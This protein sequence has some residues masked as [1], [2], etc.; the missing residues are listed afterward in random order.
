[1][2]LNDGLAATRSGK[3]LSTKNYAVNVHFG[4]KVRIT[5]KSTATKIQ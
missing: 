2:G 1:M 4:G 5:R 3:M